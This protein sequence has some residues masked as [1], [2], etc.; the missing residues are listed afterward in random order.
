MAESGATRLNRI[1]QGHS[2]D[3]SATESP[4]QARLLDPDLAAA[5]GKI[6]NVRNDD[7][8]KNEA[9]SPASKKGTLGTTDVFGTPQQHKEAAAEAESTSKG[10]DSDSLE[11]HVL[12]SCLAS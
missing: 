9:E 1:L 12:G 11:C 2:Q 3:T 4:L 8:N 7:G 6:R 10:K 5:S